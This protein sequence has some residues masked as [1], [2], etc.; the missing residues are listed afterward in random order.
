MT[1]RPLARW[2]ETKPREQKTEFIQRMPYF[3]MPYFRMPYRMPRGEMKQPAVRGT[4]KRGTTILK[5]PAAFE[6]YKTKHHHHNTCLHAPQSKSYREATK[7]G[8]WANTPACG[9]RAWRTRRSEAAASPRGGAGKLGR[10]H[11]PLTV[12][13]HP[14]GQYET[15][16]HNRKALLEVGL[17]T[18]HPTKKGMES[19]R[20]V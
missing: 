12:F 19:L 20:K 10:E 13:I 15:V 18:L 6:L 1:T 17:Q 11:T 8:A 7:A 2:K 3:R 9:T 5:T 14:N 16:R 4:C